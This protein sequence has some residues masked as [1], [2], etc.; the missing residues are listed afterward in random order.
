MRTQKF[1]ISVIHCVI[2]T[3]RKVEKD[4]IEIPSKKYN[5]DRNDISQ[6]CDCGDEK[7]EKVTE[8]WFQIFPQ[9]AYIS[10][11]PNDSC[12]ME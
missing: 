7:G 3:H 1:A 6:K 11:K 4:T 10:M 2:Q 5:I 8:I 12:N 9:D